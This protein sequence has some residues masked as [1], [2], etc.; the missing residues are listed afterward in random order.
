MRLTAQRLVLRGPRLIVLAAVRKA[1]KCVGGQGM[2]DRPV[3]CIARTDSGEELELCLEHAAD[4][5]DLLNL[6]SQ[7][8][9]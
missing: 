2:C 1:G 9:L 4:I 8:S 3:L 7:L 5:T 6:S